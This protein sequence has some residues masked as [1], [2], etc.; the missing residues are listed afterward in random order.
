MYIGQGMIIEAPRT[1]VRT[2]IVPYDS[3]RNSTSY[4]VKAVAIRRVV[5]W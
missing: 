5:N 2:R 1:G 4:M 3:W